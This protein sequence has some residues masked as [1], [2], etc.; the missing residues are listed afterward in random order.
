MF[1]VKAILSRLVELFS[2][3]SVLYKM[4]KE[5]ANRSHKSHWSQSSRG[6]WKA[7]EDK[8]VTR[9]ERA[10]EAKGFGGAREIGQ[11]LK[12]PRRR[13]SPG[14]LGARGIRGPEGAKRIKS[15][16]DRRS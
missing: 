11:E 12:E 7:E 13:K 5:G 1:L 10:W 2:S 14:S 6:A 3:A 9:A 4:S 8:E 16:I 15:N